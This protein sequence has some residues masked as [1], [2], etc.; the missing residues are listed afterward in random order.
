MLLDTKSM[1]KKHAKYNFHFAFMQQ[2]LLK[3]FYC[4]SVECKRYTNP[5]TNNNFLI[6]PLG[7]QKTFV[8]MKGMELLL[9][10]NKGTREIQLT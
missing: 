3:I 5:E 10:R 8:P 4:I 2:T 9:L 6:R 7:E 1:E